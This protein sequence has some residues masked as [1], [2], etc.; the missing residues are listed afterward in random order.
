MNTPYTRKEK[1]VGSFLIIIMI[2]LVTTL[3]VIGR[4]K[5]WFQKYVTYFTIF[6]E[7]YNLLDDASVK[8]YNAEIGKVKNIALFEDKVKVELRILEDYRYRI[9]TDSVAIVQKPAFLY[10]TEYIAIQPGSDDAS[11]IPEGGEILSEHRKSIEDVLNEVGIQDTIQN[12]INAF[13]DMGDIIK[14]LKDP[15]G[16]LASAVYNLRNTITHAES[17]TRDIEEGKGS[18]G[19][20]LKSAE[21]MQTILFEFEKIGDIL[22]HIEDTS[23]KTPETMDQIQDSLNKVKKI[24]DDAFKS[25]SSI[26]KTLTE[27]EAASHEIP[28]VAQSARQGIQEMRDTLENADKIIQSLQKNMLIISNLP[29]EPTGEKTDAGLRE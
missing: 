5:D 27:V 6:D 12:I 28:G 19:Q 26:K 11:V 25:V 14:R 9:K 2:V 4:G 8:L 15:E 13:K 3:L 17:I 23:E 18:A 20:L 16:A 24:L 10:G 1:I 29:P 22:A 21:L 7:S